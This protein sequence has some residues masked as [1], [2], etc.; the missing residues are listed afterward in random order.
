MFLPL[1]IWY[2]IFRYYLPNYE[3]YKLLFVCK[4]FYALIKRLEK[5]PTTYPLRFIRNK[6]YFIISCQYYHFTDARNFVKKK[7]E[8]FV[9][10]FIAPYT[11]K[12]PNN[13]LFSTSKKANILKLFKK[14]KFP[15]HYVQLHDVLSFPSE[16]G[17]IL[18]ESFRNATNLTP[19]TWILTPNSP[20]KRRRKANVLKNEIHQIDK[21][22]FYNR[23]LSPKEFSVISDKILNMSTAFANSYATHYVLKLF[24]NICIIDTLIPKEQ[25][26]PTIMYF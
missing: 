23:E 7:D 18:I 21:I 24:T 14:Y 16:I 2:I 3:R 8:N 25:N 10:P 22:F 13:F 19:I 1:E 17:T 26:F 20:I 4:I 12:K 6:Y 11:R 5:L 9:I 15:T